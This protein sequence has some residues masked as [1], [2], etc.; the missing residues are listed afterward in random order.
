[1]KDIQLRLMDDNDQ[2]YLLLAEWF[3]DSEVTRFYSKHPVTLEEVRKKYQPRVINAEKKKEDAIVPMIIMAKD[4]AVGYLQYYS[5]D[6]DEYGLGEWEEYIKSNYMHPYAADI[7][8]GGQNLLNR[9]IG[10][11]SIRV[12]I[13]R[14]FQTTNCDILLID[15]NALNIRAIRCY[16]KAGFHVIGRIKNRDLYERRYTDSVLMGYSGETEK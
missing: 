5:V 14:V 12:L 2:D 3:K 4:T 1:M 9:G 10:T 6:Y 11:E 13:Q 8:L 15:P 7:F 16:E